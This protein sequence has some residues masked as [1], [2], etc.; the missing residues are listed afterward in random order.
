MEIGSFI[1]ELEKISFLIKKSVVDG[2]IELDLLSIQIGIPKEELKKLIK[3][4]LLDPNR[5]FN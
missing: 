5:S 4:G 2:E 3:E 1:Q